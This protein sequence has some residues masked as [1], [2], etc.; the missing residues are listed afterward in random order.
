M[1]TLNYEFSDAARHSHKFWEVDYPFTGNPKMFWTRWGK[2]KIG[3]KGQSEISRY[4]TEEEAKRKLASKIREKVQKGYVLVGGEQAYAEQLS[5]GPGKQAKGLKAG[6]QF[7][8]QLLNTWDEMTVPEHAVA[9][10]KIDGL[11]CLFVFAGDRFCAFSRKGNTLNNVRHI[12]A[13]L[14]GAFDGY[15][16]DGELIAGDWEGTMHAVRSDENGDRSAFFLV[17]DCLTHEEIDTRTCH[18]TLRERRELLKKLWPKNGTSCSGILKQ[19]PVKTPGDVKKAMKKFIKA[20]FEGA[21]LKDLDSVYEFRRT[22]SWVKIKV[23]DDKSYKVVGWVEGKGK[24]LGTFGKFLVKGPKGKVSGVGSG[25][26]DRQRKDFWK[27]RKELVGKLIDVRHQGCSPD[28]G[29]RFP[30]FQRLRED[31]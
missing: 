3:A 21:V 22:S 5:Q 2:I 18:R 26:T 24:N 8:P 20:G 1:P 10:S 11:R 28:G 19:T 4:K 25:I 17:F 30:T 6:G 27:R 31:L 16:L 23:F 13:E 14:I 12:A 9:E 29:L 7:A 15:A